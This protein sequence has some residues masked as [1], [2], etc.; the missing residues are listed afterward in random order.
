MEI[1]FILRIKDPPDQN[2]LSQPVETHE[3]EKN[4]S[5]PS[6]NHSLPHHPSPS[7]KFM[8]NIYTLIKHGWSIGTKY[9]N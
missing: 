1:E 7:H 5:I 3:R 2:R 6:T 9:L 8:K 4:K